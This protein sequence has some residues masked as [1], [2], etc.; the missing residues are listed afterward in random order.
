MMVRQ[1]INKNNN[2]NNKINGNANNNDKVNGDGKH[3]WELIEMLY[4]KGSLGRWT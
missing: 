2:N 1:M 3:K 4:D